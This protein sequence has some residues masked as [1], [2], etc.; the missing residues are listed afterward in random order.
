MADPQD[1]FF[2]PWFETNDSSVDTVT[3][4]TEKS[5]GRAEIFDTLVSVAA[6]HV[7]GLKAIES[8]GGFPKAAHVLKHRVPAKTIARSGFLGEILATEYLERE[9]E[10]A[11]PVRRLRYRDTREQAMRGDDVLGFRR[12][13]TRVK[14]MKVE[15]KSRANLDTRTMNEARDGLANHK[16]RPN[17]ETLAFLECNLRE[18]GRDAEAEP[19]ADLQKQSIKASDVSHLVFTLSGN[20]PT[21][22]LQ[23]NSTPIRK[24]M[25]LRLCGCRVKGHA[26][27][28]K[29]VFDTCLNRGEADGV[30]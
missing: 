9:T 18:H 16:G 27:F 20:N 8:L 7:V 19:I 26:D 21:N 14:V 24:R 13:K 29:S 6:D 4:M 11:V 15:A 12:A 17:P 1:N 5:N 3:V 2:T 22:F 25:E 23:D 10:F 28:I 30:A